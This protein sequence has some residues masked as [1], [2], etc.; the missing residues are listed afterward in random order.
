MMC[1]VYLKGL[2]TFKRWAVFIWMSGFFWK[3]QKI[4]FPR[5]Y[6]AWQPSAGA[7][8][9]RLLL[10]LTSLSPSLP[11]STDLLTCSPSPL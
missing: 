10:G 2:P 4:Q 6:F 7:K 5:L 11:V 8:W 9:Q 3:N 1:G